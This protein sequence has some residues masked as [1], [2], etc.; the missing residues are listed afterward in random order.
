MHTRDQDGCIAVWVLPI[1]VQIAH[2][3]WTIPDFTLLDSVATY[4]TGFSLGLV[5]ST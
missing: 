4:I 5:N 3:H 2:D 1:N